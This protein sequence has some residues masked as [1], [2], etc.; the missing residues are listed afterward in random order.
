MSMPRVS[1]K[2]SCSARATNHRQ[3]PAVGAAQDLHE[4]VVEAVGGASRDLLQPAQQAAQ[5][6]AHGQVRQQGRGR[7]QRDVRQRQAE[8]LHAVESVQFIHHEIG[9]PSCVPAAV[10]RARLRRSPAT[11]LHSTRG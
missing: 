10:P 5:A 2:D 3:Q 9:S 7:G 6:D 4:G 11:A 8:D 1:H